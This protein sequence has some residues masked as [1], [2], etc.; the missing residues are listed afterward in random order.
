[1]GDFVAE[2]P[3]EISGIYT[4]E[5]LRHNSDRRRAND[6]GAEIP[7]SDRVEQGPWIRPLLKAGRAVLLV[8]PEHESHLWRVMEKE[9]VKQLSN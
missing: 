8:E 2:G 6:E 9:R 4:V 7:Q 3:R 5:Q 1:M